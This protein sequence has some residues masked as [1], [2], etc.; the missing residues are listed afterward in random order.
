MIETNP[1]C[2][3]DQ[4]SASYHTTA[5]IRIMIYP[6]HIPRVFIC[7]CTLIIIS[8][9]QG[10]PAF[11]TDMSISNVPLDHIILDDFRGNAIPLTQTSPELIGTLKDRIPPLTNPQYSTAKEAAWLTNN[12]IVLVFIEKEDAHAFPTRILNFHEIVNDTIG[13]RPVLIS[14]CPLC[15]SGLVF[16]RQI[17]TRLL[18]SGNTNGVYESDM[19]MYDHQT[20]SYWFQV[21]GEAIVGSL[22][23]TQ[24]TLL[25]AFLLPWSEWKTLYPNTQVLSREIGFSRPY[26]RDPF[27]GYDKL[28]TMLGF[29]VKTTDSRRDPKE[30]ILGLN[31]NGVSKAYSLTQLSHTAS[32]DTIAGK[33]IVIFSDNTGQ[34]GSIFDATIKSTTLSFF[35]EQETFKDHQTKSTWTLAGKATNGPLKGLHLTP[36]ATHNTFWF[37]WVAAFPH[38]TIYNPHS[39]HLIVKEAPNH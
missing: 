7:T 19:V 2:T 31:H 25:P 33:P 26:H 38:T 8:T 6:H 24:L 9:F 23:G 21:K 27:R 15:R 13:G 30:K 11:A 39:Q 34:A 10:L 29:P 3:L 20:Q 28:G 1:S 17:K 5:P 18:T 16:D 12:D 35:L 4:D 36:L 37:S 22:T 32:M 14:Y